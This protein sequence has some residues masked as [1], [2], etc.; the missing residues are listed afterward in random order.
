MPED[1]KVSLAFYQKK[2]PCSQVTTTECIYPL[3]VSRDAMVS[4]AIRRD[5]NAHIDRGDIH[6][7]SSEA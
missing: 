1:K 3:P 7:Q 4:L 5:T 2:Y 6:S